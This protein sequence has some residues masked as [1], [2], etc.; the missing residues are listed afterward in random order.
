M[1]YMRNQFYLLNYLKKITPKT[2]QMCKS[3]C[4]RF[5]GTMMCCCWWWCHPHL[6]KSVSLAAWTPPS[7]QIAVSR[8]S[9]AT[10]GLQSS[11]L[12]PNLHLVIVLFK[13]L[14]YWSQNSRVT[15]RKKEKKRNIVY[16]FMCVFNK[17]IWQWIHLCFTLAHLHNVSF[18][19]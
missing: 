16:V 17:L 6:S 13:G 11:P 2:E 3:R 7:V 19:A 15:E 1:F 12:I 18:S 9:V 5:T 14:K 8:H 4:S 10:W